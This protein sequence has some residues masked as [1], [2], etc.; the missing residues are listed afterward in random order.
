M[1]HRTD[2][3][4]YDLEVEH[5]KSKETRRSQVGCWWSGEASAQGIRVM[6]DCQLAG[7]FHAESSEIRDSA[8]QKRISWSN[9]F[10]VAQ[11]N[12]LKANDCKHG[13]AKKFR[14]VCAHLPNGETVQLA[15]KIAA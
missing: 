9:A 4:Q 3:M 15:T 11:Q 7:Y 2:P 10:S 5:I 13:V 14:P 1:S 8:G 12:Y 6:C